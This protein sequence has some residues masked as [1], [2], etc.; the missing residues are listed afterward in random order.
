[1]VLRCFRLLG[2]WHAVCVFGMSLAIRWLS[3]SD[4]QTRSRRR[5]RGL[6]PAAGLGLLIGFLPPLLMQ[7]P[8]SGDIVDDLTTFALRI[9]FGSV[10]GALIGYALALLGYK[11]VG[12]SG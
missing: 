6:G 1:M 10:V 3:V 12:R 5:R 8:E 4:V 11:I 7:F 2:L 9:L